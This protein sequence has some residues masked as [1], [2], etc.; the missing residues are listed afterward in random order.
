MAM[1][2]VIAGL[3]G[4]ALMTAYWP[5][6]SGVATTP[7]WDVAALLAVALFF[8]PRVR[9]TAAHWCGLSLIGWLALSL[10]WND[11][12]ADGQL[13]GI[14]ELIQLA[15]IGI[16]FAVGSTMASLSGLFLGAA[17]GIGINS[18]LAVAQWAGMGGHLVQTMDGSFSGLFFNRDRLAAAAA[19]I[20]IGAVAL[21]RL[22]VTLPLLAP[23]LILAPSRGAWL[24][25]VVGWF[26]LAPFKIR[27]LIG[28]VVVSGIAVWMMIHGIG[29]SDLERLAMWQDTIANLAFF[30]HG[31]GSFRE[32]F[33]QTAHAYDFNHWQSRPEHPHNEI[34]WLAFEGGIPAAL[35]GTA[36]CFSLF[37]DS[38]GRCHTGVA[39]FSGAGVLG[40]VAMPFHDPATAILVAL[41]SGHLAACGHR[42]RD[43]AV[44]R[45]M[46]LRAGLA[47]NA[48]RAR[49]V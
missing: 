26:V 25:L 30:G 20:G 12:G 39:V 15:I 44:D 11:G 16:A 8:A 28:A 21:P 4:F 18:A 14:N 45:G 17:I 13:D 1:S 19:L 24:A 34:L 41:C 6:I 35:V 47:A 5:G 36:F 42:V 43:I 10:I 31:L 29:P 40:L 48:G 49:T 22:R 46:A 7:R 38:E 2:D 23:S 9:M 37:R 3:F 27:F 33:L 32:V